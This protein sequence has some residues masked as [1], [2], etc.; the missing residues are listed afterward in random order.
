MSDSGHAWDANWLRTF[1]L[2]KRVRKPKARWDLSDKALLLLAVNIFVRAEHHRAP[3]TPHPAV[4]AFQDAE[5]Q[6]AA[7]FVREGLEKR[8]AAA[9]L[10]LA[11]WNGHP[12]P[13]YDPYKRTQIE[14]VSET[15]SKITV[16]LSALADVAPILKPAACWPPRT[17]WHHHAVDLARDFVRRAECQ[18]GYRMGIAIEG[19]VAAFVCAVIPLITGEEPKQNNVAGFLKEHAAEIRQVIGDETNITSGKTHF[20]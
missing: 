12:D 16:A 20:E 15:I 3:P 7:E 10:T 11:A 18:P 9:T 1:L 8:R 4:A 13:D 2:E 14:R 17:T 19:P 6:D 5:T